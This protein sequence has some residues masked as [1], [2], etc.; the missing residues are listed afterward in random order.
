MAHQNTMEKILAAPTYNTSES[1][2]EYQMTGA[3]TKTF[4]PPVG[5][6]KIISSTGCRAASSACQRQVF[7]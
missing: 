3:A 1:G 2:P 7:K 4:A 6:G 5:L